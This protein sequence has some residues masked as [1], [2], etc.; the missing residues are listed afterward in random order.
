MA[1][2]QILVLF[3]IKSSTFWYIDRLPT[4][5][6]TGV[7]HFKNGPVFWPTLYFCQTITFE[8]L[9]VGSSHVQIL[10]ISRAS[11]TGQVRIW[12]SSGQDQGH[13]S[14]KLKMHIHAM[15]KFGIFGSI[16]DRTMK[17]ACVVEFL[18][19]DGWNGETAIFV[20]W[21]KWPRVTK[22]THSRVADLRLEGNLVRSCYSTRN[23]RL[24][25]WS[26][27]YKTITGTSTAEVHLMTLGS[28]PFYYTV[29]TPLSII[30]SWTG[31]YRHI[32]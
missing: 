24:D 5:S 13:R 15:W 28:F 17:F 6:Y 26:H 4:S 19:Y 30:W 8:I 7:I 32:I 1:T 3:L 22:Y 20:T 21:P 25:S 31:S 9:D 11:R 29:N 14:T 27:T 12:R 23:Y 16:K 18:G 2:F 10:C